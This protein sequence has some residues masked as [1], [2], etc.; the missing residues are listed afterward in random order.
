MEALVDQT[1]LVHHYVVDGCTKE[2]APDKVGELVGWVISGG[3]QADCDFGGV[4]TWAPGADPMFNAP[5][6]AGIPF[7]GPRLGYTFHGFFLQMHYDNV[8]GVEGAIDKSGIRVHY[9]TTP[10]E[11]GLGWI[12]AAELSFYSPAVNIPPKEE[13][14]HVTRVCT[15]TGLEEPAHIS[16]IWYHAHLI[17]KEF[18]TELYRHGQKSVLWRETSWHFDDQAL[19]SLEAAGLTVY[20][21]DQFVASCV[22]N[23]STRDSNTYLNLETTD[24]MCWAQLQ[25]YP[26]VGKGAACN[27]VVFA[28][29]LEPGED[30][31][32]VY[33]RHAPEN[34][35]PENVLGLNSE[36]PASEEPWSW[37][38]AS[39]LAR[40]AEQAKTEE[41]K[42]KSKKKKKKKKK[43]KKL[44]KK[45][46][47]KLC[48]K[49]TNK[50]KCKK[51]DAKT[52]C[53]WAKKKKS[54]LV[55]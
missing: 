7:G 9:V 2:W 18:S 45:A 33:A 32:K 13:R 47:K 23:S 28:G 38:G 19:P 44:S 16:A 36:A 25:Y 12:A 10:R 30:V 34:Y 15:V 54:C 39:E 29:A 40:W 26:H 46:I 55:A 3:G 52:H 14:F 42:K 24:E 22:Y 51:D 17:G 31:S 48:K 4:G 6:V 35:V 20:N 21:G 41:P 8:W 43:E 27:G 53:K 50:K 37:R 11:H 5:G 1:A 49:A